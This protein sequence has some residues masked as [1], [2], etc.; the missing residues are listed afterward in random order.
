MRVFIPL[1]FA[2]ALAAADDAAAAFTNAFAGNDFQAKR[3]AVGALVGSGLPDNQVMQMLVGVL[4]DRQGGSTA[5]AALR[6]KAGLPTDPPD[7]GKW[8]ADKVKKDAEEAELKRKIEE[9]EA[10]NKPITPTTPQPP[11]TTPQPTETAPVERA[12]ADDLGLP[13][14]IY[15][16]S[17]GSF[18]GFIRTKRVDAD[19]NLVSIRIVRLDGA[20][21]E[22]IQAALISRVQEDI[23]P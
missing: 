2:A 20:G 12:I 10:K 18:I 19:G 8:L 4:S 1:L 21:E 17:G 11:E 23:T 15:L 6:G 14:R 22:T 9:L 7:W 13:D 16:K 5:L 3:A